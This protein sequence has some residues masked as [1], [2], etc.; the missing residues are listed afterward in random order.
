MDRLV[1][2]DVGF[3]KTEI[4]V[5]AAFKAVVDG[6]QV[7]MLVP[8]TILAYQH[9][10]TFGAR[11]Q[12]FP[13]KVEMLSRFRTPR[14][15]RQI[16]DEVRK[17]KIDILIGT[18]RLLSKDVQFKNL[19]LLIVDEEQRFGVTHKE[20]LK[21]FRANID[22]LTLT[23]T[24]IP[25]TLQFSLMG[26]RDMTN[27]NTPP[28]NRLPIHTEI[29]TFNR[30]Y[31]RQVILRELERD[32]QVFFVHNRVQSIDHFGKTLSDLIPEADVAIA[33][34]QM[35][36]RELEKIMVDFMNKKYHILVATMIIES[37]LDIP[38]VNTIVINR[39]DMLGLAQ[40]Y[41]LRGRVGR[42][43]QRAYAYLLIPPVET[44]TDDAQKRL[45]AIEEFSDLGSGAMLAMRD[46]EIRG[47]GNL[48]GA[49]QTGFIDSLGFELYNKIVDEAVKELKD[50]NLPEHDRS[51]AID[52]QVEIDADAF[53]PEN[54]IDSGSERVDIYKRLMEAESQDALDEIKSELEDR[55]G[56]LPEPVVNLIEYI[57]IRAVGQ[58]I[59]FKSVKIENNVMS[60][61]FADETLKR[62][63]APFPEWIGAML[64]RA[65]QPFEFFQDK[66]L[67]IK[68]R[69]DEGGINKL[70][71]VRKF[72]SSLSDSQKN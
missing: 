2:G 42:S 57:S 64:E 55:F 10:N 41:Q 29:L 25:R 21:T 56:K 19:G 43:H 61:D 7:A 6:K 48:L 40:L 26:A 62:A 4:A 39:A 3:G 16:I 68:L 69:L 47:A 51:V 8:T 15:Q 59:G 65:N 27:I 31:L 53:L 50:E 54:Y 24:P 23:A 66:G 60:A 58:D 30:Q 46:L 33:H 45:K 5:R 67:G 52:T 35:P 1:C 36:E 13:V 11:L 22:V 20:K 18:H 63:S 38:N 70:M 12:H 14:E 44:L 34:G 49:E 28:R 72:L 71:Q 9:L 32:G 37:G 17:G